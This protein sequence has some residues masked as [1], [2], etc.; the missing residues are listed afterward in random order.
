MGKILDVFEVFLGVFEKDRENNARKGLFT[1][2]LTFLSVPA[3]GHFFKFFGPPGP[4]DFP[5]KVNKI[6]RTGDFIPII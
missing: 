5:G 4:Y 1:G 3:G 2:N 6:I